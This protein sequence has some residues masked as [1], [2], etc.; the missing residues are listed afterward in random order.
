MKIKK[1]SMKIKETSIETKSIGM[2]ADQPI[3][4]KGP[5]KRTK[6]IGEIIGREI[7]ISNMKI[8][9]IEGIGAGPEKRKAK[10]KGMKREIKNKPITTKTYP[11]KF[12]CLSKY[13]CHPSL[14]NEEDV[15]VQDLP[16][17]IIEEIKTIT[18]VSFGIH[19]LG[20]PE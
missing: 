4:M 19:F 2:I 7:E 10:V 20:Y 5:G 3:G 16:W 1:I 12:R 9:E 18:K 17:D 8:A 11:Q 6:E 14:D 15:N 13:P